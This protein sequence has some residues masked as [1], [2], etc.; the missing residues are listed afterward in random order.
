MIPV[1]VIFDDNECVEKIIQT[2]VNRK[3]ASLINWYTALNDSTRYLPDGYTR[4]EC[5]KILESLTEHVE[6][7]DIR[8]LADQKMQF[9]LS[10]ILEEE[11]LVTDPDRELSARFS[12]EDRSVL[13][14]LLPE[15]M[16]EYYESYDH[17]RDLL[18]P[19]TSYLD[20]ADRQQLI[21]KQRY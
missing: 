4:D 2:H 7:S 1:N 11:E 16:I 17:Y 21:G 15:D 13:I 8:L 9:A 20:L 14:K 3:I 12:D 18:L 5:Q 6:D 10:C 19:E